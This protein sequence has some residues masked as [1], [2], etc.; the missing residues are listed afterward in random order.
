MDNI[1]APV[2]VASEWRVSECGCFAENA[3][4]DER[5]RMERF[6]ESARNGIKLATEQDAIPPTLDSL[7]LYRNAKE[8]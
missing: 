2:F 4:T 1:F 5:I 8:L 3:M 7:L 6:E